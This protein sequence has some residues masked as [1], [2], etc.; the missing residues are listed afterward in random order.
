MTKLQ[1]DTIKNWL[2]SA[3]EDRKTAMD[4]FKLKRYGWSLFVFHL[5]IEKLLKAHLARQDKEV[6][7][8]HKLVKLARLANLEIT[9]KQKSQLAEISEYNI[10]ARYDI[11]KMAFYKKA[12]KI[13]TQRWLKICQEIYLWL[14]KML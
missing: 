3:E 5:A 13:Y 6:I 9:E 10:E 2:K 1:K 12:D 11:E 4:L 7:F 8:T 14:R